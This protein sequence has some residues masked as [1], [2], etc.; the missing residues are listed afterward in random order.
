[1][2]H[3]ASTAYGPCQRP[4]GGG[5]TG[6]RPQGRPELGDCFAYALAKTA[7]EALLFKGDDFGHTDITP[8]LPRA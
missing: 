5:P 4:A 6:K 2:S 8:A 3:R 1:V 7:G